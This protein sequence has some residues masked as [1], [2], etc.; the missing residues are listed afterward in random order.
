MTH[1]KASTLH[2]GEG[3]DFERRNQ[4]NPAGTPNASITIVEGSGTGLAEATGVLF[5]ALCG[6]VS[7][8]V[9]PFAFTLIVIT[10]P[11]GSVVNSGL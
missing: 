2:A 1:I 8:V 7:T 5:P 11:L 3:R 9:V 10:L 6:N 4:S